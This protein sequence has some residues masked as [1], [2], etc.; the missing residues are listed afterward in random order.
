MVF[1]ALGNFG[2]A[3]S[4]EEL[5]RSLFD[6]L[7]EKDGGESLAG[8]KQILLELEQIGLVTSSES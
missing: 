5:G 2:Q 8:L 4:E 6:D 7:P 3:V 1:L